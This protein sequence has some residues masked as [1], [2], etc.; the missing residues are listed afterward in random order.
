M[1][2]NNGV[3]SIYKGYFFSEEK[4][5]LSLTTDNKLLGRVIIMKKDVLIMCQYFSP[6]YI[7]S[8]ILPTELAESLVENKVI[9]DVFFL[10][11]N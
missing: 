7:F 9:K 4:A 5:Y 1:M 2:I 6:E 8:V 10:N 11:I 3:F